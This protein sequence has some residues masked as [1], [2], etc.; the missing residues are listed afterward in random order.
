ML[1]NSYRIMRLQRAR[2][3][4]AIGKSTMPAVSEADVS[5]RTSKLV[6][7]IKD[8]AKGI[9]QECTQQVRVRICLNG[10]RAHT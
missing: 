6:N 1:Q 2:K 9:P 3:Q 4:R 5:L 8:T 10:P 7:F